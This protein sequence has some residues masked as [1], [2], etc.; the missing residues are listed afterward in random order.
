MPKNY[1]NKKSFVL[2]KDF[3]LMV[4]ALN[5]EEAGHI[6]KAIYS[7]VHG[8]ELRLP[9][10]LKFAFIAFEQA[11]RRDLDKWNIELEHRREAGKLGGIAKANNAKQDIANLASARSAK[12]NKQVLKNVASL[13][14]SVSVNESVNDILKEE[15]SNTLV[16]L[17]PDLP[18][19]NSPLDYQ[20]Y[21]NTWNELAQ[22][23]PALSKIE[24]LTDKRKRKIKQRLSKLKD[25]DLKFAEACQLIPDRPFLLGDSKGGW[26]ASF[27]WLV[28]NDE[29]VLK[30]LEGNYNKQTEGQ[31]IWNTL[32]NL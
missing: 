21:K 30:V 26:V 3:K 1:V 8:E 22:R 4:D 10:N 24:L 15:C 2:Y 19:D 29:N 27:D 23:C 11:L 18:V 25:F 17:T 16:G 9:D 28:A 5:V 20:L 14:D 32:K 6:F 13:A 7:F 12:Q 31:K